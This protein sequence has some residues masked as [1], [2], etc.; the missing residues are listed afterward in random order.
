MVSPEAKGN[1]GLYLHGHYELHI[2]DSFGVSPVTDQ[3]E[4]S[5]YRFAKPIVNA[6]LPAGEWQ[7]YDTRFIAPRRD[8]SGAIERPGRITA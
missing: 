4:G 8:A 1:S 5:L 7:V 6:A 3:D 2:Y